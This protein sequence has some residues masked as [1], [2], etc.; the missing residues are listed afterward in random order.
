MGVKSTIELTRAEAEEKFIDLWTK[1][2]RRYIRSKAV[3][4]SSRALEDILE[5][6]DDDQ[7][8]GESFNNYRI[9]DDN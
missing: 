6:M 3:C 5:K 9:T 7:A 2:N 1:M 8:G 4:H